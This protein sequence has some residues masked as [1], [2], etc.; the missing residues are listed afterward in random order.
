MDSG[1]TYRKPFSTGYGS[2]LYVNGVEVLLL[3][4]SFRGDVGTDQ[5]EKA[6]KSESLVDI[7]PRSQI[8]CIVIKY[9]ATKSN[10]RREG[11]EEN[12]AKDSKDSQSGCPYPCKR[13]IPAYLDCSCGLLK[14]VACSMY[15]TKETTTAAAAK[16]PP[17]TKKSL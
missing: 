13:I 10:D 15:K 17:M 5:H 6:G 9:N 4:N 12:N 8:E 7:V 1:L 2:F 16:A 3:I 14:C 11:N